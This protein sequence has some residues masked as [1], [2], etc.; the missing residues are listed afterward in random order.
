MSYTFPEL[1]LVDNDVFSK[2]TALKWIE[3]SYQNDYNQPWLRKTWLESAILLSGIYP[4]Y[5][6]DLKINHEL[7]ILKNQELPLLKKLREMLPNRKDVQQRLVFAQLREQ[8]LENYFSSK[9]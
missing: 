3:I 9:K 8:V 2:R 7:D 1:Q 4:D 6:K 5:R